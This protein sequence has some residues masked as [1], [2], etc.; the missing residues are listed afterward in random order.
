LTSLFLARG[1]SSQLLQLQKSL[2]SS[3]VHQEKVVVEVVAMA[4][5]ADVAVEDTVETML[6]CNNDPKHLCSRKRGEKKT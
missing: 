4:V 1:V 6:V 5:V 3:N 2:P